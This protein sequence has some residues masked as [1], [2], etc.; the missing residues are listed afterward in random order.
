MGVNIRGTRVQGQVTRIRGRGTNIRGTRPGYEVPGYE[1]PGYEVPGYEV[2]GYGPGYGPGYLRFKVAHASITQPHGR[3]Q[4]DPRTCQR[5]K[6]GRLCRG[7]Y[8]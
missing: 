8:Y 7:L 1:V 3:L 2:P 6:L 5:P 4:V